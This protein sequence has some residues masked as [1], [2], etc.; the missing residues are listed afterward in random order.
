MTHL[1]GESFLE[2]QN[3]IQTPYVELPGFGKLFAPIPHAEGTRE[4]HTFPLIA[5]L[6]ADVE[7]ILSELN[8]PVPKE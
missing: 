4:A 1:E 7:L 5:P 8:L 6:Y 2:T 3:S